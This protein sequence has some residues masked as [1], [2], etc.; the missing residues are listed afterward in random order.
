MTD[1]FDWRYGFL[2][3]I[4]K[5]ET[6]NSFSCEEFIYKGIYIDDSHKIIAYAPITCEERL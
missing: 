3:K 2:K 5:V 6:A 1:I 4:M